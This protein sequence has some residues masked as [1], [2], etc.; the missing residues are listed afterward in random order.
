MKHLECLLN[1]QPIYGSALNVAGY[2]LRS[3]DGAVF[4]L[5]TRPILDV[6]VGEQQGLISLTPHALAEGRWKSIPK[7]RMVLGY[8]HDFSPKENA[9][10]QLVEAA[11]EG[12]RL[13][14]SGELKL[15]S[16]RLLEKVTN[17]IKIDVMRYRPDQLEKRIGELL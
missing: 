13:A 4:E 8:F 16:L 12:Y 5:F 10:R 1:R 9:A 2:E 3:N 6:V 11:A 17:T 14:L 7:S 15:E